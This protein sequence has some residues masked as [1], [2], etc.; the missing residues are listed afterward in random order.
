VK[1]RLRYSV[2]L[3]L[4][5]MVF[6]ALLMSM[7]R[8]IPT[9]AR[10]DIPDSRMSLI[11]E[12]CGTLSSRFSFNRVASIELSGFKGCWLENALLDQ[13]RDEDFF[14]IVTYRSCFGNKWTKSY[15]NGMCDHF[16][17]LTNCDDCRAVTGP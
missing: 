6:F 17:K 15:R 14:C 13:A 1:N 4:G 3:L 8:S 2:R 11:E 16:R 5:A 10:V 7:L 9:S 12:Q